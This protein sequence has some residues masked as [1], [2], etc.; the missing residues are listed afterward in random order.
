MA[1][2]KNG[3]LGGFSG[4][5]GNVVG[6]QSRN[7]DLMRSVPKP[8]TSPPTAGELANRKKFHEV[9]LWLSPIISFLRVGFQDYAPTYGGFVAAKSYLMKN[10]LVGEK[11]DQVIDSAKVLVSF[12]K[13]A[14]PTEASVTVN[15]SSS[16]TISWN[17]QGHYPYD[18]RTMYV[19]YEKGKRAITETAGP[20]RSQGKAEVDLPGFFA[21]KKVLVYLAFVQE[22]RKHRS[23]SLFLGEIQIPRQPRAKKMVNT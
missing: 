13:L 9:Q 15:S 20:K 19:I 23:N 10:A 18:E 1:V 21:G 4:K 12:G 7:Q 6:Y 17:A 5:V 22:N 16:L 11:P 3:I 8:R 2:L 14:Q